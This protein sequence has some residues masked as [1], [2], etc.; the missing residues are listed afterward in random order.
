MT[1]QLICLFFFYLSLSTFVQGQAPVQTLSGAAEFSLITCT[2]G[3][4]VYNTFGHSAIRLRD[5][6]LTHDFVYNYGTFN[7]E[8]P[9][10]VMKFVERK[11]LYSLSKSHFRSFLNVYVVEGRGVAEQKLLLD[12]TQKQTLF[13]YLENNYRPENREYLYDFFYD[14]CATIIRDVFQKTFGEKNIK[15]PSTTEVGKGKRFRYYLDEYL[16]HDPWLNFGIDLILGLEADKRCDFEKQMFLP[17][18]LAKNLGQ[19]TLN[20]KPLMSELVWLLPK[21]APKSSKAGL[22]TPFSLTFS[23]FAIVMALTFFFSKK[24]GLQNTVDIILYLIFGLIGY[25]LLFMWFGTDHIATQSNLNT[26]WA[27]PLFIVLL[28]FNH[29]KVVNTNLFIL[30]L[31]IFVFIGLSFLM[32]IAKFQEY[33]I[34][35]LPI[36]LMLGLRVGR[37]LFPYILKAHN[38]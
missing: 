21:P 22:F 6:Y 16:Q 28:F 8:T 27:N 30:R 12:S 18:Y 7:F 19:A 13:N 25:F 5:P 31:I 1:K 29:R 11:L 34:A 38:A 24:R 9:G 23:L 37:G 14:N 33:N 35:V 17:D 15:Y 2:P 4:D 32:F 3:S 10:F 36:V 26:F 20:G